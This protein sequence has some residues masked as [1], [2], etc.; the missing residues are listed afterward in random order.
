M[1]KPSAFCESNVVSQSNMIN[2]FQIAQLSHWKK[3][4]LNQKLKGAMIHFLPEKKT[5]F[6][7]L[8]ERAKRYR[9]Q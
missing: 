1:K 5:F 3:K 2:K 8:Y 4:T 7:Y 9:N 6:S